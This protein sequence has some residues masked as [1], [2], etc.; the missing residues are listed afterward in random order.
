MP[1]RPPIT[2]AIARFDDL[3]ALAS[4]PC[5][6][7]TRRVHRGAGRCLRTPV[8]EPAGPPPE[9]ADRRRPCAARPRPGPRAQ[10]PAPSNPPGPVRR[11]PVRRRGGPAP[12]LRRQR[13]P[14]R[15]T[16][17]RDVRN[18]IHLASRGLQVTP[19]AANDSSDVPA[20]DPLLTPREG[21]V[22]LLLRQGHG[23]A[24]IALELHIGVE[25]CA[26]THATS[27]ASWVSPHDAL[28]SRCRD[29]RPRRRRRRPPAPR[30]RHRAASRAPGGDRCTTERHSP[31]GPRSLRYRVMVTGT[32]PPMRR[33]SQVMARVLS[34]MQPCEAAVPS[35]PER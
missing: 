16:Q 28:W 21:D 5:W 17:A 13:L 32:P 31:A 10:R 27:T 14:S 33:A 11:R 4:R 8:G 35:A 3:L 12:R 24:Q 29:R 26:R 19:L 6:P 20:R 34:R 9:R 1:T 23:N 30:T 2:V 7:T 18:T 25:T 22:L 15:T